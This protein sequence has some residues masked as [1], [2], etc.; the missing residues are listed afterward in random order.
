MRH[1]EKRRGGGFGG[2]PETSDAV[3]QDATLKFTRRPTGSGERRR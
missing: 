2:K 3:L 1:R